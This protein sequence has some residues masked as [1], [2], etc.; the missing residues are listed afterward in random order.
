M[1]HSAHVHVGGHGNGEQKRINKFELIA[2]FI[3]GV[4]G[5]VTAMSSAESGLWNGKMSEH[6][7]RANKI[8]TSAAAE[9]SRATLIMSNDAAIDIKAKEQILVSKEN[10]SEKEKTKQIAGYL[11][12]FQMSEQGYKAMGFPETLKAALKE[13]KATPEDEKKQ[14][15]MLDDL[16]KRA[17]ETDLSTKQEYRAEMLEKSNDLSAESDKTFAEGIEA[18]EN[19]DRFEV[20]DV[21]FAVSLFFTGISLVFHSNIRWSILIVGGVFL[22]FGIIYIARIPWTF[23]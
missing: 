19:G 7:G 5:I 1:G 6:Y 23:S 3:L 16:I 21:V 14:N 2:A 4:A 17:W 22:L 13:E 12:V 8:A 20:A 18:K 9:N 10:P 11:Y 15:E